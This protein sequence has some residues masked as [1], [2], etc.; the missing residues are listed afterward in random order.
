[1]TIGIFYICTGKYAI[2]WQEFHK[3]CECFFIP[4]ANKIYYVFT[5]DKSIRE[6][7]HIKVYKEKTKG[8]PH[9]SLLRFDMFLKIE[10]EAK[11]CDYLF[12]FNSNLVFL[13]TV[14]AD[15]ILPQEGDHGL[16]AVLHPGYY[17]KKNPLMLPYEKNKRSTAYIPLCKGDSY[18]YFMGGVNGGASEEYYNLIHACYKQ[19]HEDMDNHVLALYHDESHLNRYLHGKKIK[20]L[21][22][23]YGFPEGSKL[24]IEPI[25]MIVDKVKHGGKYFDKLPKKAYLKRTRLF[26]TRVYWSLK[27]KMNL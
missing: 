22:P 15:M 13:S 16:T 17:Q 18:H 14:T 21:P 5:D 2:F 4:D 12:F 25:I 26:C 23:S 9:D 10:G 24:P 8:F 3:S 7:Q 19:I 11:K 1:M 27:W 20:V 6:D